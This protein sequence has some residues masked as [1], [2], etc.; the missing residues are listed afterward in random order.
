M[1][2]SLVLVPAVSAAPVGWRTDGTGRYPDAEP[3]TEWA[4]GR[5]VLWKTK[6]PGKSYGSPILVDGRLFVASDPAELIC[7]D[8][9][10]G[11]ILWQR[12]HPLEDLVGAEAA[13]K[14]VAEF[15]RLK[16]ERDR[17]RRERDK[18]RNDKEKRAELDKQVRAVEEE[19]Q[20]LAARYPVP[21]AVGGDPGS[22]NSAAT[23]A[24]DGH[25][26]FAVF[27]NGMVGAY[28]V[29]GEKRW[30]KQIEASPI[31]FGHSS[32]PVLVGDK[33]LVHYKDLVALD[34][35]TGTEVWRV[36]LSAQY[37]TPIAV[38]VGTTAAVIDPSGTV[39][40]VADG[41]VLLRHGAL[42]SSELSL[43]AH[44]GILYNFHGRA[45]AVRLIPAGAAAVKLEQLWETRIA[46]GRRTPSP[47]FHDGL[48]YGTTT[49]G[50]LDVLDA[51]TGASV[52]QQRLNVGEVYSS[53]T[54][55]GNYLFF[56]GTKGATVVVA[57][58]R[59]YREVARNQLEGFGSSPVFRGRRMYVRTRQHLYCIGK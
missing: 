42:A 21:P 28:S 37:A 27:G 17:L 11:R 40:R 29:T 44:D 13:A 46:G 9:A 47:V 41:K 56:G 53:A 34:A 8:A 14:A 58:G 51:K 31:Y 36:H 43:I 25:A 20:E 12:S 35:K 59:E 49:D 2:A 18:A 19:Y 55:A 26:V 24:C 23:P 52:Y 7:I 1:F 32:S 39:V 22:T 38:Q 3:P 45:R 16:A 54:V 30:V 33:V 50:M 15:K 5:N 6:L 4:E 48:L 57:P 10:D